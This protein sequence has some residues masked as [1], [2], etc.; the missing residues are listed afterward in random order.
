MWRSQYVQ[1]L[2]EN[3]HRHGNAHKSYSA[4]KTTR[5]A[6]DGSGKVL[7]GKEADLKML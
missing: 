3:T 7:R 1:S 4:W 2:V 6:F 5:P